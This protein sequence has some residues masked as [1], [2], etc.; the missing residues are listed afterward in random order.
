[1]SSRPRARWWSMAWAGIES[2]ARLRSIARLRSSRGS[3]TSRASRST[4]SRA[5]SSR[6][7]ASSGVLTVSGLIGITLH[8]PIGAL[9]GATNY[10]RGLI[11][12]GTCAPAASALAIAWSPTFPVVLTSDILMAIAGAIFAPTVAAI[13][14]GITRQKALP[15]RLGGCGEHSRNDWHRFN[16]VAHDITPHAHI[17]VGPG[18]MNNVIA[19]ILSLKD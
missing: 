10:K 14:L 5:R 16:G 8:T 11:I 4:N 7:W 15:A 2:T 13:T 12:V 9:I 18:N 17:I 6:S 1:M 3:V 19:Y